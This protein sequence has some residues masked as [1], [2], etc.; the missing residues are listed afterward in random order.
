ML[1]FGLIL[2]FLL[3]GALDSSEENT[4]LTG[5]AAQQATAF[6]TAN[7]YTPA[8]QSIDTGR[9]TAITRAVNRVE[10]AVVS[11]N[12]ITTVTRSRGYGDP[13]L[14]RFFPDIFRDRIYQQNVESIGSG[15]IIS[16]DGYVVTNEHVSKDENS[17]ITVTTAD[18]EEHPAKLVGS[19]VMSDIALLKIEGNSFTP[20]NFGDSD[21]LIIGEWVIA[22]GNP[23][24][25]FKRKKPTVTV[26]VIS[27]TERNL[28][29]VNNR[30][31]L[32]M[33]QTDAAIN[34]GNSGGPLCNAHGE[35]I[36]MNTLIFSDNAGG[37]VGI[38][39]AIPINRVKS[40]VAELKENKKI[41][42]DFWVG[43][44]YRPFG[45]NVAREMGYAEDRGI[46]VSQLLRGSPAVK[47]GVQL[48]DIVVA[49]N[50][51]KVED[52]KS[53]ET[54]MSSKYLRVGDILPVRVWRD[55]RYVDLEI[56]L[57]KQR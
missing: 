1:V 14:R 22:L 36:G 55:G 29:N 48:G 15:F 38:G 30:I 56:K 3:Y 7:A 37:N 5:P 21:D 50:G 12:V 16:Q 43:I 8:G 41:E 53:V 57:E 19:D 52:E 26:G 24:G 42:R 46:Y 51:I 2:G 34:T 13:F 31:Y 6:D 33:I 20:V 40:I 35:V 47:A 4:A 32:D 18:G 27:A 54:A 25:L 23:F 45:P 39:F 10:P 44:Y 9:E 11:I 28:G 49:I 17:K